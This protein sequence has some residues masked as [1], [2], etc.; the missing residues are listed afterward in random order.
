MD[1]H[2][3]VTAEGAQSEVVGTVLLVAI[4]VVVASTVGVF[5][6]G[7]V[8]TGEI[9]RLALDFEFGESDVTITHEGGNTV[10]TDGTLRTRVSE[11]TLAGDDWAALDGPIESGA[12]VTLT[13]RDGGVDPWDG[14]TVSVAWRSADGETSAVIA[15]ERAPTS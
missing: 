15:R 14:E 5:A 9:P 13:H 3:F 12:N 10:T 2:R 7:L 8:G 11:G 1:L 4:T 6:F